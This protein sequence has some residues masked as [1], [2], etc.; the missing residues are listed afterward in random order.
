MVFNHCTIWSVI[1][2]AST[3]LPLN[4][5]APTT[6]S[7]I[8]SDATRYNGND[9]STTH[10]PSP[11]TPHQI[12]TIE[13]LKTTDNALHTSEPP[14][15]ANM[16]EKMDASSETATLSIENNH[17]PIKTVTTTTIAAI[18]SSNNYDQG[19]S[20]NSL[21]TLTLST[22]LP[23]SGTLTHQFTP[24]QPHNSNA[25]PAIP[26]N[27]NDEHLMTFTDTTTTSQTNKINDQIDV[28]GTSQDVERKS[29]RLNT[30]DVEKVSVDLTTL[31]SQSLRDNIATPSP[32]LKIHRSKSL[33]RPIQTQSSAIDGKQIDEQVQKLDEKVEKFDFV[34]GGQTE[35]TSS[36][37]K[38][39]STELNTPSDG[40]VMSTTVTNGN[41]HQPNEKY[42]GHGIEFND[43]TASTYSIETIATS[44]SSDTNGNHFGERYEKPT[45]QPVI[46]TSTENPP[47]NSQIEKEAKKSNEEGGVNDLANKS[48]NHKPVDSVRAI[49]SEEKAIFDRASTAFSE[50]D[51]TKAF[52]ENHANIGILTEK[53]V[54]SSNYGDKDSSDLPHQTTFEIR[55]T[56]VQPDI[57]ER[58]FTTEKPSTPDTIQTST[59]TPKEINSMLGIR[60][61][62]KESS[63][64]VID[65]GNVLLSTTHNPIA[66]DAKKMAI[67]ETDE[68][69]VP[70]EDGQFSAQMPRNTINMNRESSLIQPTTTASSITIETTSAN[71]HGKAST[72]ARDSDTIFY[73]SNTEVKVVESS[74]PTPNTKQEN[75]FFPALYEEDVIIDFPNKNSTGWSNAV[76]PSGDKFE[77]DII[78]SPMKSN[79][80]PTKLNDDNLSISYVGESF[81]DI[82]EAN[83]DD[84]STTSNNDISSSEML[85][86]ENSRAL[87]DNT[88]SSNV[89]IEAAVIGNV[90]PQL[91]QQLQ[92]QTIGVPIIAELPPQIDIRDLDYKNDV[93]IQLNNTDNSISSHLPIHAGDNL[94]KAEELTAELPKTSAEIAA[95]TIDILDIGDDI[96]K[97]N[98]TKRNDTIRLDAN[99][100]TTTTTTPT[101]ET[102][103]ISNATAASIL[104]DD[105]ELSELHFLHFFLFF[106]LVYFM[107]TPKFKTIPHLYIHSSIQ[108]IFHSLYNL[109]HLLF[110]EW[111]KF[112]HFLHSCVPIR[113]NSIRFAQFSLFV[114][115]ARSSK[116]LRAKMIQMFIRSDADGRELFVQISNGNW[117][118][119]CFCFFV[120]SRPLL[121]LLRLVL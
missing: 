4:H 20:N 121:L 48:N 15:K 67:T 42:F 53:S 117:L 71:V 64:V 104:N 45:N 9:G 85:S 110:F 47:S 18:S 113:S 120:C 105:P 23:Q 29:S 50:T 89:I 30:Y 34:V 88:I 77:E 43:S 5:A 33:E 103:L 115:S 69:F 86:R 95:A 39:T 92:Q 73:I 87:N 114:F 13:T 25:P 116:S 75:Q 41:M 26:L 74:V 79:F 98:T 14:N 52:T 54:I 63:Q 28:G 107:H 78:L 40:Q 10:S 109:I 99:A 62:D 31:A 56:S 102:I 106:F 55:P 57:D 112:A 108:L 12:A 91:Q 70:A 100:T 84:L 80:D 68:F 81:I 119:F 7:Q 19:I 96:D 97:F 111:N 49:E 37:T 16:T 60:E 93:A 21:V 38:S 27:T 32:L 101:T 36:E 24:A 46:T 8:H 72:I 61:T 51:G 83:S 1:L 3:L 44:K 11:T 118:I 82:K 66:A 90:P 59:I 58:T 76:G 6:N 65:G 2:L 35:T 17:E 94:Q 22:P